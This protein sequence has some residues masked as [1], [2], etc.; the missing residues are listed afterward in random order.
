LTSRVLTLATRLV[1]MT[2]VG[3][4]HSKITHILFL[5]AHACLKVRVAMELC[6][7][8]GLYSRF[9]VQPVDVLADYTLEEALVLQ[10][11]HGHV[12]RSWCCLENR[13][14]EV[15]LWF[16]VLCCL[17]FPTSWACGK[18][19]VESASVVRNTSRG[20]NTSTSKSDKMF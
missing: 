3:I 11:D 15:L 18:H 13:L 8:R 4:S 2:S 17:L 9:S 12:C 6:Q 16:F 7:L 10:L 20:G 19:G 5:A 14:C 1:I